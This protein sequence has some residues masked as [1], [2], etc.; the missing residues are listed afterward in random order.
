MKAKKVLLLVEPTTKAMNR[1]FGELAKPS[2]KY[3]GTEIISFPDFETLGKVITGA[4]LEL[5]HVIRAEKPKSIQGLARILERDF[6][7]VYEDVTLLN[8]FG[9]IELKK[10]GSRRS[11]APTA[12]FSQIVLAA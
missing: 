7:N 10:V 4:R 1:A 8:E 5:M 12:R 3:K 9:L 11:A 2:K 6:K